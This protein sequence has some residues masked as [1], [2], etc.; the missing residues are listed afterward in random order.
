MCILESATSTK[1]TLELG[2]RVVLASN[3]TVASVIL[4]PVPMIMNTMVLA[5]N[6]GST[7]IGLKCAA[8]YDRPT[9]ATT[10]SAHTTFT[11]GCAISRPTWSTSPLL[12]VAV[13]FGHLV[14]TAIMTY[15]E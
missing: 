13:E 1:R 2:V 11:V 8:G 15:S 3:Q 7:S 10:L 5:I 6:I 14:D 12:G 4:V 9:S